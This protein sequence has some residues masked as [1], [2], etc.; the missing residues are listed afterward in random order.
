[1]CLA[2][3]DAPPHRTKFDLS[4][5]KTE[6][7]L[8]GVSDFTV[9]ANGEKVL[10][11]QGPGMVYCGDSRRA[12]TRRRRLKLDTMEV[13]VDPRAEWNQMYHEVWRIERDFLYDPQSPRPEYRGRGKEICAVPESAGGRDD[14]NYLFDEMLGELTV[15]HMFIGGGDVPKPKDERRACW[16]R[17]TKSK[18]GATALRASTTEKTGILICARR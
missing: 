9:S 2:W 13:Y 16:A 18:M 8:G 7:F 11:R 5:R 12:E 14:L 10:Y 4:T 1:M 15:G 17:T 6:P 3:D